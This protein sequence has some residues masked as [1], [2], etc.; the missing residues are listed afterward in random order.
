MLLCWAVF[1]PRYLEL[2]RN[3]QASTP[4][5]SEARFGHILAPSTAPPFLMQQ[6]IGG[7]PPLGVCA[8]VKLIETLSNGHLQV[9]LCV[10]PCTCL[11]CMLVKAQTK[12][13]SC[14]SNMYVAQPLETIRKPAGNSGVCLV[15]VCGLPGK[16]RHR[17]S[18]KQ[19][20]VAYTH[21]TNTWHTIS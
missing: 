16:L 9:C 21:T 20:C 8:A 18:I 19:S 14:R 15:C 17:Q 1:E 7:L 6:S 12:V 11:A 3:L 2:F 5:G 4:A 10:A 13:T